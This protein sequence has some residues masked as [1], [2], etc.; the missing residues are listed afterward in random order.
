MTVDELITHFGSVT[1]AAEFFHV[2]PEAIYQWRKRPGQLI[3][4]GRAAQ[5]A[6][7]SSGELKY[8]PQLYLEQKTSSELLPE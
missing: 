6:F 3:P 1:K 8:N 4:E 7:S 5:A 2:S